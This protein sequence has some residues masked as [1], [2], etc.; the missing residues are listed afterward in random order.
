VAS[1]LAASK[2]DSSGLVTA[3]LSGV[4]ALHSGRAASWAGSPLARRG[5]ADE[6]TDAESADLESAGKKSANV[7]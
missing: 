3:K 1:V 6:S 7:E 4:A 2:S 5:V